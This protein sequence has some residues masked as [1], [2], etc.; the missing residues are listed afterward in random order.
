MQLMLFK[1]AQPFVNEE[2]LFERAP[3]SLSQF[4]KQK[5]Q[6]EF[7]FLISYRELLIIVARATVRRISPG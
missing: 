3:H 1:Y 5:L 4:I 6:L 2:K 7:L